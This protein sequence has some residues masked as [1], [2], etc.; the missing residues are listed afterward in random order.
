MPVRQGHAGPGLSTPE[1]QCLGEYTFEYALIPNEGSW[2]STFDQAQAF[3]APLRAVSRMSH[4]GKLKTKG[5]FIEVGPKNLIVTALK[6]AEDG[7]G[8]IVRFWNSS[9]K[10]CLAAVK[11]WRSPES[12]FRCTLGERVLEPLELEGKEMVTVSAQGREIVT[13]LARF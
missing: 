4:T 3:N 2:N 11:F 9:E 8:L 13:M 12:V 5:S 10:A 7:N 6:K 1:A